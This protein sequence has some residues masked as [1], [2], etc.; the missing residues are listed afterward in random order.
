M[1]G[2]N[3]NG[4]LVV[5]RKLDN[6][7]PSYIILFNCPRG[8]WG[9]NA[10]VVT[11]W[12]LGMSKVENLALCVEPWPLWKIGKTLCGQRNGCPVKKLCGHIKGVFALGFAPNNTSV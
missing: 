9:A 3:C 7:P 6:A 10:S 2:E 11:L 4:G 8:E 1:G 5:E 12:G